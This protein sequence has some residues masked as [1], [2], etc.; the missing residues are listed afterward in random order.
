MYYDNSGA[1]AL[2][3]IRTDFNRIINNDIYD[4]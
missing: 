3:K 2:N 4:T 1:R